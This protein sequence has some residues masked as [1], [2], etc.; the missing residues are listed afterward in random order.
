MAYY[1]NLWIFHLQ[2]ALDV[3]TWRKRGPCG[4]ERNVLAP[5]QPSDGSDVRL[6]FCNSLDYQRHQEKNY[7]IFRKVHCCKFRIGSF[8][9]WAI[10]VGND[11]SNQCFLYLAICLQDDWL[12]AFLEQEAPKWSE[13]FCCELGRCCGS[14]VPSIWV[15]S[16]IPFVWRTSYHERNG[17]FTAGRWKRP[18]SPQCDLEVSWSTWNGM[19]LYHAGV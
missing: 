13:V 8:W 19:F 9:L 3:L 5:V 10:E 17:C 6:I 2:G 16:D 1:E 7:H 11:L 14:S 15:L 18:T 12:I 4:S